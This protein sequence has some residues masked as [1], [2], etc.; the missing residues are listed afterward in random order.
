M[1][2]AISRMRELTKI[3]TP[4]EKRIKG[5]ESETTPGRTQR[6]F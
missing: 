3:Q 1:N 6:H 2:P 4:K 5:P